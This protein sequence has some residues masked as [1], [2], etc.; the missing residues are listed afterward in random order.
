LALAL[1]LCWLAR[2][3][4]SAAQT[5]LEAPS[6]PRLVQLDYAIPAPGRLTSL[7]VTRLVAELRLT[8]FTVMLP[9]SAAAARAPTR[10]T[11]SESESGVELEITSAVQ[12]A[13]SHIVLAGTEQEV[14]PLALQASE[15]LRAGLLPRAA[16]RTPEAPPAAPAPAPAP[17]A[18]G[19]AFLDLGASLLTNGS[20]ADHLTLLSFA[21]GYAWPERVA[22]S[23]TLDV[24]LGW[25]TFHG[26]FGSA[27]YRLWLAGL[28]ADYGFVHWRRGQATLGVYVGAARTT[29]TGHPDAPAESQSPTLWSLALGARAGV[30]L[31]LTQHV[32]FLN[33]LRLLALSPNPVVSVLADERRLGSP[34]LV[35]ELGA[36]WG[37]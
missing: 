17:A 11:I 27:D 18:T 4:P 29:T 31:R 1:A 16:P 3:A 24:P 8:G 35:L 23:A 22:L 19:S 5:K 20:A 14:G 37:G 15:F 12:G 2:P 13:A 32:S 6:T 34:S 30:E 10:I 21:A 33:Q 28:S 25:A 36:R 9:G 7:A 26:P